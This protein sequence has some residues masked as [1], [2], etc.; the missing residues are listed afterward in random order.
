M[1]QTPDYS[2][3]RSL[4][5]LERFRHGAHGSLRILLDALV[6]YLPVDASAR[7]RRLTTSW[8]VLDVTK[9]LKLLDRLVDGSARHAELFRDER[10]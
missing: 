10:R 2:T 3:H 9:L 6:D 8:M 7:G 5:D 4:T 1:K